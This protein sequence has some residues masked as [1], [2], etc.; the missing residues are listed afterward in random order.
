MIQQCPNQSFLRA[1]FVTRSIGC[2]SEVWLWRQLCQINRFQVTPI[3]WEIDNSDVYPVNWPLSLRL[4]H[5]PYPYDMWWRWWRRLWL[6]PKRNFYASMG[7]ERRKLE[8]FIVDSNPNIILG[9]FGISSLRVIDIALKYKIPVVAHFHGADLSTLLHNRWYRWNLKKYIHYFTRIVVVGSHQK[10]LVE[11]WG[12]PTSKIA[13]IPCGVPAKEFAPMP[14]GKG[15]KNRL[16]YLVVGRM[17]PNKGVSYT[18][19]A[20]AAAVK[21]GLDASLVFV[22]DGIEMGAVRQQID[23][24]GLMDRVTLTGYLPSKRVR[25]QMQKAD[26]FVQHSVESADG[27]CEGFGVSIAEASAMELPVISTHCGG[28]P[29]QI[30]NG[31]NGI[32]VTQRDVS[33]MADAMLTLGNDSQLRVEMGSAGRR[34]VIAEFDTVGQIRKLEQVLLDAID[35]YS[36]TC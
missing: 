7:S 34:R 31:Y 4:P 1:W 9:A 14:R 17:H 23:Q 5:C 19:D 16:T 25:E 24:L 28:I 36:T 27:S 22:G 13:L 26:V 20:F 3:H 30:I 12:V 18:I 15:T 11:S 10:S 8:K 2:H 33:A 32:L 6:A 21:Q 29:D 35:E